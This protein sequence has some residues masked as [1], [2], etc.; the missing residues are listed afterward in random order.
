MRLSWKRILS[1]ITLITP[2]PLQFSVLQTQ[3]IRVLLVEASYNDYL[4]GVSGKLVTARN[5]RGTDMPFQYEQKVEAQ[6]GYS[7][8]LTIDEVVQHILEKA[9]EEAAVNCGVRTA[10]VA[11]L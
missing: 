11:L 5:A 4:S 10:P 7:L 9:V 1:A 3:K 6:N 2:W 8:V